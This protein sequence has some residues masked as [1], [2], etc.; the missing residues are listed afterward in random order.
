MAK[1]NVSAGLAIQYFRNVGVFDPAAFCLIIDIIDGFEMLLKRFR[2]WF[3]SCVDILRYGSL[4]LLWELGK[5][6]NLTTILHN[7]FLK[8]SFKEE[9]IACTAAVK[10]PIQAVY[11]LI[12]IDDFIT[13]EAIKISV[14]FDRQ[15]GISANGQKCFAPLDLLRYH[16]LL[17]LSS[18]VYTAD[19]NAT[20]WDR[21]LGL[22]FSSST[23]ASL[24]NFFKLL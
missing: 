21:L 20:T 14:S 1:V 10:L 11:S 15:I 13:D 18:N 17:N 22:T 8:L 3:V 6:K 9:K 2:C 12:Q 7:F 4:Y 23:F 16:Y 24:H 19:P 5:V